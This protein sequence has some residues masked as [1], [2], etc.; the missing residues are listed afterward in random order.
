LNSHIWYHKT[1]S[2]DGKFKEGYTFEKHVHSELDPD[3]V[4]LVNNLCDQANCKVVVS[5]T[6]RIGRTIEELQAVLNERGAT[7]DIIDKTIITEEEVRGVE[8]QKWW[9]DYG[10][11]YNNYVIFDDDSDMMIDQYHNFFQIDGYCG[12]TPTITYKAERFLNTWER[13]I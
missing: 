3:A 12:V 9:G 4:I 2:D 11:D 13:K 5:S 1:R 6:W 8:I 10:D 7:F